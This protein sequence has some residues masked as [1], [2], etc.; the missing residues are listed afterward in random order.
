LLEALDEKES[1]YK[2]N[3]NLFHDKFVTLSSPPHTHAHKR[4]HGGAA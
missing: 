4:G 2:I 3:H 1:A